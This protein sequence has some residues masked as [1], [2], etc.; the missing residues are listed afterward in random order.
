MTNT[1]EEDEM[2]IDVVLERGLN[3][4]AG[5]LS[6]GFGVLLVISG[7]TQLV[8]SGSVGGIFISILGLFFI[9]LG[10]AAGLGNSEKIANRHSITQFGQKQ[11]VDQ[12]AI[13]LDG[14]E[15]CIECEREF[16]RGVKRRYRDEYLVF[17]IP[18]YTRSKGYNY[19]CSECFGVSK[20][21][22]SEKVVD[23][24]DR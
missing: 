18:A 13:R 22:N 16:T 8:S 17:G 15:T 5:L 10:L 4:I 9:S 7:V 19:Y 11:S 21:Q 3:L 20:R 14:K 23:D 24:S 1:S 12:R 2:G 6:L